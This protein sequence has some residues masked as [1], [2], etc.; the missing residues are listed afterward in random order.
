MWFYNNILKTF[1]KKQKN[2]N[3]YC[4]SVFYV[5]IRYNF[6]LRIYTCYYTID[7]ETILRFQLI[8][9]QHNLDSAFQ[10]KRIYTEIL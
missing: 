5:K 10:R 7:F 6:V 3:Q 8:K 9:I 4:N 2:K 1:N